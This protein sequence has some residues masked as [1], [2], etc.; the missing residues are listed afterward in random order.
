M[1][2]YRVTSVIIRYPYLCHD[3]KLVHKYMM[4]SPQALYKGIVYAVIFWFI[5]LIV[6][7]LIMF[8]FIAAYHSM[9]R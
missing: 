7:F 1:S 9:H 2:E 3:V 6:S 8:F 4:I 5:V